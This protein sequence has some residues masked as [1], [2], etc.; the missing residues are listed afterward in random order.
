[1]SRRPPDRGGLP[2][3]KRLEA[4][5]D[6][7]RLPVEDCL[8]VINDQ[9]AT[10]AAAVRRAIPEIAAFVRA[11]AERWGRGGRLVYAGCGTS[12]RLGVLDASECPPTFMTDPARV[13]GIIAGG[14]AALRRSSE[15]LEDDPLG[16]HADMDRLALGPDDALLGITA[17]GTTPYVLGAIRTA[18]E[19]GAFAGLLTCGVVGE[20]GGADVVIEVGTGAEV[21][22]GS[23]R[24]KAG[25]ATKMVLNMISTGAMVRLGKTYGNLMVDV[26]ATNEKLRDRAA[27]IVATLAGVGREE[28]FGMVEGAGGSVKVALLMRWRGVDRDE[29]RRLLDAAHGRLRE[30]AGDAAP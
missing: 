23:T 6:L 29:A 25:T 11:V 9:D 20:T 5:A 19:R 13:V 16:A 10:V 18:R 24:M 8:R 7:D 27:R 12:G 15:G 21:L 1:V 2:T 17:G 4:S 3:E 26:S 30:A 28:A 22:T 14:D